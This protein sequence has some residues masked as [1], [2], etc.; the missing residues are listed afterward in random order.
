MQVTAKDRGFYDN[1]IKDVGDTFILSEKEHFSENW[2]VSGAIAPAKDVQTFTGYVAV[3]GAAGKFVVKDAAGQMVGT[4]TGN[5]AE[6]EA[7]A[8][9]LNA[10][11]AITPTQGTT[12]QDADSTGGTVNDSGNNNGLPDA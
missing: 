6:A 3:R 2:M 4:F 10:G 11:G 9:R 1:G 5:K 7:E 12:Q 8:V